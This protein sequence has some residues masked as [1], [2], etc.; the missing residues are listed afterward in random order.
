MLAK[1]SSLCHKKAVSTLILAGLYMKNRK[2]TSSDP[3]DGFLLPP[4]ERAIRRSP[5][6][7]KERELRRRRLE[8]TAALIT[9]LV[10]V[11]SSWWQLSYLEG[12]SWLFLVLLNINIILMLVVL[13]LVSRSVVKLFLER[14][15]KIFGARLRTRLVLAFISISFI[16]VLIMFLAANRVVVTSVD[17]WF[18]SQVENSMQAALQIGQ[19]FYA[20]AAERLRANAGI[21]LEELAALPSDSDRRDELLIR[22]QK[23]SGLALVG[24]IQRIPSNPPSYV[25]RHWHARENFI[26]IWQNVRRRFNWEQTS[27]SGFD[28]VLWSEPSGDYVVCSVPV[29]GTEGL[30][31]VTAETMGKGLLTELEKIS[32]GFE[33][34]SQLKNLKRPLKLSFSLVLGL[35][36]LVVIFGSVW[37][38]F[39]LS[40]QLTEPILALS[41][42]TVKL[43]RGEPDD[44]VQDSG[45]DE[46]GQLVTS[47]NRMAQDV[48]ESRERLTNLNKLLEERSRILEARNQYIETVL[49]N[50]ATGVVTLDAHGNI[51]TMNKAA[52]T[53]FATSAKR[54]EGRNPSLSL[55]PEYARLLHAMYDFL[56]RHPERPW[57]QGLDFVRGGRHWKLLLHVVVLPGQIEKDGEFSSV[58]AVIE[59]ITELARMQRFAAWQEVARRIAH[60]IKN[61]LTPIKL[62]A[63]R[64]ER[65]FS[66][67]ISDPAFS[68]STG[69]IVKEVERMQNMVAEFSSFAAIPEVSLTEG[70]LYPLLEELVVMFRTSHPRIEWLLDI[71]SPLPDMPLD[72]EAMH[73]VLLN[74][75]GNAAEALG[76]ETAAPGAK[77]VIRAELDARR[78]NLRVEIEDNGPGLPE[79]DAA[80]LFEPY[81]SRKQGGTGLGLSI[82]RALVQDH[83]GSI[84]ARNAPHGGALI[85]ME[86]PLV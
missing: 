67:G 62:S 11:V 75:M 43:A 30:Y 29:P 59:D 78:E 10:V 45:K 5:E 40:R 21:L 70:N 84:I 23:Q 15:R 33:E 66:A 73:R 17:Y 61:P 6:E 1:P 71:P 64:L 27:R 39:R 31:L 68:Q 53:I 22:H 76:G 44:P 9:V 85:R 60:E 37:V 35:L 34:Y 56:R 41:R 19:N 82:V 14:K 36:S 51:Q 18:K 55:Q 72:A 12:D 49:E 26:P 57:Q 24:F 54:W 47:F 81:Y 16:P 8:L 63:Q 42:G 77:V 65:K 74:L 46:L 28:S 80:K 25:E 13:F 3:D 20:A 58:V 83:G 32:Q 86:F 2:G 4:E 69:L 79:E 38:A 7:Q 48:R 50:I 52:C